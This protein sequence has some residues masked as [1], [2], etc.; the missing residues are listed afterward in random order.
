MMSSH[1]NLRP[2]SQFT[3]FDQNVLLIWRLRDSNRDFAMMINQFGGFDG[4]NVTADEIKYYLETLSEALSEPQSVLPNARGMPPHLREYVLVNELQKVVKFREQIRRMVKLTD[5]EQIVN[6][7]EF[8]GLLAQSEDKRP[9]RSRKYIGTPEVNQRLT[10]AYTKTVEV[11]E[12]IVIEE[13]TP[14][15]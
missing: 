3:F 4:R 5:E 9:I 1:E 2:E 8:F 6:A 11:L 12:Q 7:K 14:Q 15:S 10:I 13:K